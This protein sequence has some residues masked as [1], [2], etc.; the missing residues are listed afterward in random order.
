MRDMNVIKKDTVSRKPTKNHEGP[1]P[2]KSVVIRLSD[3][4]G[5]QRFAVNGDNFSKR[6]GSNLRSKWS[7]WFKYW[8]F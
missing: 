4:N 3:T 1:Y 2:V 5:K 6:Y 8:N 7:Y